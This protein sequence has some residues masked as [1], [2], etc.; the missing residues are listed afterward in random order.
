M[1]GLK[2]ALTVIAIVAV[3]VGLIAGVVLLIHNST[4]SR[5]IT[6]GEILGYPSQYKQGQ[7]FFEVKPG[8]WVQEYAYPYIVPLLDR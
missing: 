4:K 5:C 7:C 6:S 8:V 2:E 1:K 3:V